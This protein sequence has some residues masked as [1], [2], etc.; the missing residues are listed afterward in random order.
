M[1]KEGGGEGRKEKR[2]MT[3]IMISFPACWHHACSPPQRSGEE[4]FLKCSKKD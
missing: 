2:E 1:G 3:S 4:V